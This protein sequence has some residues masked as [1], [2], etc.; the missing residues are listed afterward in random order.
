MNGLELETLNGFK[1]GVEFPAGTIQAGVYYERE[2]LIEELEKYADTKHYGSDQVKQVLSILDRIPEKVLSRLGVDDLNV[3]LRIRLDAAEKNVYPTESGFYVN[4][5]ATLASVTGWAGSEDKNYGASEDY[6]FIVISPMVPVPNT[7]AANVGLQLYDEKL[8][9][10]QNVFVYEYNGEA[11][12][13]DLEVAFNGEALE[14][15]EPFYYGLTT[16]FDATK[17]APVKPGVYFA[18]YNYTK[19][20]DNTD[21]GEMELRRIDSDSAIIIIKQR[22]VDLEI[23][24]EIVEYDGNDHIADIIVTDKKGNVVNDAGV[25][26]ISGTV[27]VDTVGTNVSTN[28]LYGTVNVDL[29]DGLQELWDAYCNEKWGKDALDKF[30]PSDVLS[31]FEDCAAAAEANAN[32]AI[33]VFKELAL[34][35]AV[36]SALEKINNYQSYVDVSSGNIVNKATRVQHILTGGK[37]YF[38]KLIAEFKPLAKYDDNVF[39]TFYD[40]DTEADKLD[41]EKTGAYLYV[42]VVTDPDTTTAAGKGLVIIHS[43]ED[44]IMYDTHVPYNGQPQTIEMDDTSIR[45]D[46]QVMIDRANNEV[47]FFLDGD[48]YK[49]INA[50]LASVLGEGEKI[51][52]GTDGYVATAYTKTKSVGDAVSDKLVEI[53]KDKATNRITNKFLGNSDKLDQALNALNTKIDNLTVKIVNKL[54]DIDKMPNDTRIVVYER[55]ND[56]DLYGMPVNV[57]TYEF[58]GY[59]YDVAATR[60]KLVIEPIYILIDDTPSSKY[61][62]Q[63][64]PNFK[65]EAIVTY[66]SYK[67]V[68]PASVEMVELTTLPDANVF[69]YDVVRTSGETVGF[70]DLS[71]VAELLNKSGNYVLAECEEDKQDFEIYPEIGTIVTGVEN[72]IWRMELDSVVQ[73]NFYPTL[74]DFSPEF[75]FE[76]RAGVV[77]WTGTS[78]PTAKAQLEIGKTNTVNVPGW[79]W[80]ENRNAW[81][82]QTLEIYA[83]DLGENV[84]IRPYVLDKD[85]NPVYMNAVT[86]Y[87][88]ETFAYG[89]MNSEKSYNGD[90]ISSETKDVCA[91]LLQ[92]GAAAQ[93]YFA[94]TSDYKIK[95]LIT[96]IPSNFKN[97]KWE[98]YQEIV[99]CKEEV[100]RDYVDP[101]KTDYLRELVSTLSGTYNSGIKFNIP[102]LNLVGAIRLSVGYDIT[103]IDAS[104][105]NFKESEILFWNER[106]IAKIYANEK[107]L[108]YEEH[109]YNYS[110][111][112]VKATGNESVNLGTY[113]GQSGHIIAN[114]LGESV[115]F[116]CRVVMNDGTVYRGGIGYYSGEQA[117]LDHLNDS[118][119]KAKDVSR[120]ILMYSEKMRILFP[121]D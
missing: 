80:N 57:G 105:I 29:P 32:G 84:Y 112:L 110:C 70:Y 2:H 58:F 46:I 27:N 97:V 91:S 89:V 116:S 88:P 92:Y 54:E 67:G 14:D 98:D 37:V 103:G 12:E 36:S 16:R 85:D 15:E 18:G 1:D 10:V 33:E 120:R 45:G 63:A 24:G 73:L 96:V 40:L 74:K 21:S 3:T 13:R 75:D 17:Q 78:A 47:K 107:S 111:P 49:A 95:K 20:V 102:T 100:V 25:T 31:F 4:F 93:K 52:D 59:D 39:V 71:V 61:E 38:D 113:R 41:Y 35:N 42:G 56:E 60:G 11:I 77:I 51:S 5:A 7:G 30:A 23:K 26:V 90:S 28:D 121:V 65:E 66:Y 44:Y 19:M 81:Y 53:I 79:L 94:E 86:Y 48:V 99:E 83:K 101:V 119:S 64:D 43:A 22:E 87:S 106:D 117:A 9:N 108:A 72:Y 114:L 50:V 68:A 118:D 76:N 104:Q 8:S 62:G 6:G 55:I 82:I 34:K 109:N 115:Y 69:T